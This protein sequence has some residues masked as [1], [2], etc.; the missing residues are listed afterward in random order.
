V[1]SYWIMT[2]V[3]NP[4][5]GRDDE[6]LGGMWAAVAAAFV[7]RDTSSAA[8]SAGISR[9]SATAVSCLLCFALMLFVRPSPLGMALVLVVGTLLLI[10]MNR[11]DEIITMA[12]TTLVVM[13]VAI[14]S[15]HD[16]L[17][18]PLLRFIDTLVGVAVGVACLWVAQQKAR[19]AASLEALIVRHRLNAS[20]HRLPGRIVH[21]AW[22]RTDDPLAGRPL[23]ADALARVRVF[24]PF[25]PIPHDLAAKLLDLQWNFSSVRQAGILPDDQ[26]T[27]RL[28]I[29]AST[30]EWRIAWPL[31]APKFPKLA[32][33]GRQNPRLE[34]H[35]QESARRYLTSHAPECRTP[36]GDGPI[37]PRPADRARRAG[38]FCL[39]RQP[40]PAAEA[41]RGRRLSRRQDGGLRA[42]RSAPRAAEA[43]G[44]R[45]PCCRCARSETRPRDLRGALWISL[46][47]QMRAGCISLSAPLRSRRTGSSRHKRAIPFS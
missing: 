25:G 19:L 5:V 46:T 29:R 12:I 34:A 3:L 8:R 14:L 23:N 38:T 45:T 18:Q 28:A 30:A 44:S 47:E 35:R 6:L 7:F 20:L 31:V 40:W 42:A 13:V 11:R 1:I 32:E 17:V 22:P 39:W 4:L 16:A 10:A 37:F 9:L 43:S 27:L 41:A 33:G 24:A 2:H 15:P 26:E 21:D 36:H